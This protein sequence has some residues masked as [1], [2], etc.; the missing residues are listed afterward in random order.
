MRKGNA[1][2]TAAHFCFCQVEWW[3]MT[4][5]RFGYSGSRCKSFYPLS[6]SYYADRF[7]VYLNMNEGHRRIGD[8]NRG[9]NF[10]HTNFTTKYPGATDHLRHFI[11]VYPAYIFVPATRRKCLI[12]H[13]YLTC[14][15]SLCI[16]IIYSYFNRHSIWEDGFLVPANSGLVFGSYST[17][18]SAGTLGILALVFRSFPH[19]L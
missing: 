8:W 3:I 17:R 10:R 2:I 6:N 15:V 9:W 18:I 4:D 12:S 5:D 7:S 14:L 13:T 1:Q 11:S 19:I 16:F